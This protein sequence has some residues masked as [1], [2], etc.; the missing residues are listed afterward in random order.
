MSH[1]QSNYFN[2][3]L[4]K[5]LEQNFQ[6]KRKIRQ[7]QITEIN[8]PDSR[9]E[10]LMSE[11]PE[12]CGEEDE[13]ECIVPKAPKNSRILNLEAIFTKSQKKKL[14]PQEK[15]P[16]ISAKIG[17]EKAGKKFELFFQEVEI[18]PFRYQKI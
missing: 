16:R 13:N 4:R 6:R 12:D 14:N 15:R 5:F 1:E 2:H 17:D 8:E 9:D 18:N 11:S 10:V 7:D 3:H